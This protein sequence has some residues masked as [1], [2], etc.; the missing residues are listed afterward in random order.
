MT[1]P[2]ENKAALAVYSFVEKTRRMSMFS[3]FGRNPVLDTE[4]RSKMEKIA[5]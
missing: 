2:E 5:E 1:Y 3:R 4:S